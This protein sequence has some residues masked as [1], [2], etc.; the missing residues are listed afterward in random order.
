MI[1]IYPLRFE[2]SILMACTASLY[3]NTKKWLYL[4]SVKWKSGSSVGQCSGPTALTLGFHFLGLASVDQRHMP[5]KWSWR[6]ERGATSL[7]YTYSPTPQSIV[8][9]A[10]L[11]FTILFSSSFLHQDHMNFEIL[12]Y[13]RK[14][15]LLFALPGSC[16]VGGKIY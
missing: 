8:L 10:V 5:L 6:R 16:W 12:C 14:Q 1:S 15:D 3:P 11:I 13:F 4:K 9:V 7:I 2:L